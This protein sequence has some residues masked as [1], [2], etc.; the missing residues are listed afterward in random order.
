MTLILP[1]SIA[2]SALIA[3]YLAGLSG[4]RRGAHL[5]LAAAFALIA[6]QHTLTDLVLTGT[7][8][9]IAPVRPV[10]ALGLPPLLF[11]HVRALSRPHPV[12][13]RSDALHLIGP[14]A[15]LAL[16][17]LPIPGPAID[18]TIV[19][20]LGVY[21]AA[22]MLGTGDMS[23]LIR[24]WRRIV[25]AW[26][27][28]MAL[29]DL[30]VMLELSSRRGLTGSTGMVLAVSGLIVFFAYVLL[31]SLH[32]A[33]PVAWIAARLRPAVDPDMAGRL[34][35]HMR[36]VQPWRDPQL[37]LTRLARQLHAPQR[38][39]SQTINDA[40]GQSVSRWINGYRIEEAKRLILKTPE[41]PFIEL[42]LD[43]GFQT[44][45]NF[46]KAFKEETGQSPGTWRKQH[47]CSRTGSRSR[48][49]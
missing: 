20:S 13:A 8:P 17:A 43:C 41:R 4:P 37:T 39:V 11:L 49:I 31:A 48:D 29:A 10:L 30:A 26:M 28:L 42:M 27:G 40:F 46:A 6:V 23:P 19:T 7:L 35:K 14:A 44:R 2:L 32:R 1:V 47:V 24:R 25:A 5:W 33:G 16:L 3:L 18:L 38:Q 34:A 45:A 36:E 22:V 21:A 15:M 12:L 9:A